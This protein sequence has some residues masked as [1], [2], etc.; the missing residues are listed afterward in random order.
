MNKKIRIAAII[1]A[2]IFSI[3]ILSS[4]SNPI[5]IPVPTTNST[6]TK[7][8]EIIATNLHKPWA[9]DFADDRIFFTEKVGKI[10]VINSGVLLEEPLANLHVVDVTDGGLLGLALHPDFEHNHYLYVFYTYPEEN[11]LWNKVIR[12]TESENKITDAVVILDKIPGAEFDNGGV[13]K[14]GPDEKLYIATG[15][16]TNK[17]AAQDLESLS[18]KILRLNDDGTTPFDNPFHN[19]VFSYGH[20]NPQGMAWDKSGNLYVTEHGP[21]KNDEINLVKAGQNFGWPDQEC[22]GDKNFVDPLV[23]YNPS[24]EPAGIV[25]YSSNKLDLGNDLIMATLRGTNL[26]QLTIDNGIITAQ[27]SIL[28]G[29]GRIRDVNEGPDGYLYI[30]TGN[31]DGRGFPDKTDDKLIRI[32]K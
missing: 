11:K 21:T 27:K 28:G 12:I 7:Y 22:S 5:V 32:V 10:R 3:V 30:F 6:G 2:V 29:A 20:R 17:T 16:A 23:C 13:I 4:P 25:F 24:L 31:T 19:L 15:D 9:M 26:Y 1:G 18:G 8:V 14:F